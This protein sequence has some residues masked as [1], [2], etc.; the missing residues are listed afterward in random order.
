MKCIKASHALINL[1][2][3][4][5]NF[6]CQL[7]FHFEY[8]EIVYYQYFRGSTVKLSEMETSKVF[9]ISSLSNDK[10]ITFILQLTVENNCTYLTFLQVLLFLNESDGLMRYSDFF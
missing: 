4:F 9:Q 6:K 5:N 1:K 8:Y 3:K 7:S 10:I 2:K